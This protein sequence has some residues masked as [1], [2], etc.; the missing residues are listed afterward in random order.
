[1]ILHR[2]FRREKWSPVSWS[3]LW[4]M[5]ATSSNV[6]APYPSGVS[7]F[8]RVPH[9]TVRR[10]SHRCYSAATTKKEQQEEEAENRNYIFGYGSLMCPESRRVTNANLVQTSIATSVLIQDWERNWCARTTTGYTAVGVV[11]S[12]VKRSCMGMLLGAI[13]AKELVDVDRREA[14]YDRCSM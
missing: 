4:C 7:A 14:S 9:R 13:Q 2:S 8:L 1:M 10:L 11:P 6:W 12:A 3:L 5:T